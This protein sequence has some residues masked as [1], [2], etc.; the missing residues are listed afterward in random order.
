MSLIETVVI[1]YLSLKIVTEAM[2]QC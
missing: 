1:A 2:K